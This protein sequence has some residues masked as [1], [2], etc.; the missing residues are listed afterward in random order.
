V[1]GLR[2]GGDGHR[3]HRGLMDVKNV[4]HPTDHRDMRTSSRIQRCRESGERIEVDGNFSVGS[5]PIKLGLVASYN[6]PG[7]NAT[8]VNI[9]TPTLEAKRLELLH[10]LMP[11]ATRVGF[12]LNPDNPPAE[13][14]LVDAAA[15]GRALGVQVRVWRAS[16]DHEIDAAFKTA[17]QQRLG[18]LAVAAAPFF[19]TRRT[20]IVALAARYALPTIYHAREFAAVG[21]LL[22]Y[23]IDFPDTSRQVGVYVG[24]I[25]NGAAPA[26][27][28]VMEPTK[29]ELVINTRTAKALGLTIPPSLLQ[30]ADQVIE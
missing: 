19:D 12:L 20:K 15:A 29:F 30:R 2:D 21:G 14:Q 3:S 24:R 5:D 1:A 8:G 7:G 17:A 6:R 26:D 25:L 16:T 18:A 27:L 10:E 13:R 4:S 9:L 22:S 28:P 11:Q 23:G